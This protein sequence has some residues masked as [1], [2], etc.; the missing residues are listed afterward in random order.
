MV[1]RGRSSKQRPCWR[2]WKER[3]NLA[4]FFRWQDRSKGQAE[5]VW[6]CSQLLW[7]KLIF[8]LWNSSGSSYPAGCWWRS[9]ESWPSREYFQPGVQCDGLLHGRPQRLQHND[10]H[11]LC[12]CLRSPWWAW[13]YW[14]IN[15]CL[16]AR[17]SWIW[18]ARE[19]PQL[20]AKFQNLS[21]RELGQ[22]D[23]DP[24]LET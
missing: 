9:S 11:R 12:W 18:Y 14:E 20:E 1:Q 22:E 24:S 7:R 21:S 10:M 17:R 3:T 16:F 8:P 4:W 15:G 23:N 13:P 19:C 6:Q 5:E 2:Y